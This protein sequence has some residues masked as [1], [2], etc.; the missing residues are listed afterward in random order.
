MIGSSLIVSSSEMSDL[1]DTEVTDL[2]DVLKI[3]RSMLVD[4]TKIFDSVS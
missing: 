2:S 4:F 3:G 1:L